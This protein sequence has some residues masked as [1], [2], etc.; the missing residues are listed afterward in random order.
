VM[1]ADGTGAVQI[2]S[3]PGRDLCPSWQPLP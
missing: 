2:S 1:N 3:G